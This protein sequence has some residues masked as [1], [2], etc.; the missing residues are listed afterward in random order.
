MGELMRNFTI[1]AVAAAGLALGAVSSASAA[2]IAR[3]VYKAPPVVMAYNWS[4]F[5]VGGNIG[6]GWGEIDSN[7]LLGWAVTAKPDG[8]FGGGQI[9]WNWQAP[10]SPWVW[11]VEVDSQWSGMKDSALFIGGG[12]GVATADAKMDYFG[13]A[14]LRLGYAWDRAMFYGTGGIA[15]GNSEVGGSVNVGGFNWAGSSSNNHVGWTAGAGFE[16]ALLDNWSA[17]VEYLYLDLGNQDYFGGPAA[18]GFDAD[19]TAHTVKVGLNY[20]FGYSKAPVIAK[21]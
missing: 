16:W 14:R 10:G 4:G 8:F 6:W 5:Y 17:K 2:D 9:G 15:W 11:G 7:N 13:T 18:G 1:A 21:Y 20:R 12:G 19:V 3:P